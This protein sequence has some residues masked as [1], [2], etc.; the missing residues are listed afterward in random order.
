M[1]P[2]AAR[3]PLPPSV[4]AL[5]DDVLARLEAARVAARR[6]QAQGLA[7]ARDGA[8]R[9]LPFPLRAAAKRIIG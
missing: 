2:A 8:L 1:S 5:D 3:A 4:A 9:F 7:D 6:Q